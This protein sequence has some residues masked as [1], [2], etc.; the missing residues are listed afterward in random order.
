MG[1]SSSW[2]GTE[3]DSFSDKIFRISGDPQRKAGLA[4]K[5][6]VSLL[7]PLNLTCFTTVKHSRVSKSTV[8]SQF[9]IKPFFLRLYSCT[10]L[11]Q[12]SV[13]CSPGVGIICGCEY[14]G[15][16]EVGGMPESDFKVVELYYKCLETVLQTVLLL[17]ILFWKR[18]LSLSYAD[19]WKCMKS[20]SESLFAVVTFPA[21]RCFSTPLPHI[22]KDIPI[23]TNLWYVYLRGRTRKYDYNF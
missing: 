13:L 14:A 19:F 22:W 4:L 23:A 2:L 21:S 10:N 8:C 17:T 16:Q 20:V 7:Q 6:S 3:E 11:P 9:K 1:I 15:I 18:V 12:N 5:C